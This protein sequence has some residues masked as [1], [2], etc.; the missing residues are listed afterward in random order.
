MYHCED[1]RPQLRRS[2]TFVVKTVSGKL[3]INCIDA[4]YL[5]VLYKISLPRKI[6]IDDLNLIGKYIQRETVIPT[7]IYDV[8][9]KV[10]DFVPDGPFHGSAN[11][12]LVALDISDGT[13]FHSL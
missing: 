7:N 3:F 1:A 11:R 6:S 13:A 10:F 12:P 5:K 8:T 2:S 9:T 4:S